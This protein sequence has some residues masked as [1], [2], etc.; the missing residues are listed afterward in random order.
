MIYE[1]G[2]ICLIVGDEDEFEFEGDED[3]DELLGM[4]GEIGQLCTVVEHYV[5][6]RNGVYYK[7]KITPEDWGVFVWHHHLKPLLTDEEAKE[8]AM[9]L[10]G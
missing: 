6:R 7:V 1:K 10:L 9:E 3:E 5:K 2:Q 4:H 8:K